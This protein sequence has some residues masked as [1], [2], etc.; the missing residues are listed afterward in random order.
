MKK[1]PGKSIP[2]GFPASLEEEKSNYEKLQYDISYLF[3]LLFDGKMKG[4]F[5]INTS[6]K[7]TLLHR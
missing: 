7:T 1:V 5:T 3:I 4:I 6:I 2:H